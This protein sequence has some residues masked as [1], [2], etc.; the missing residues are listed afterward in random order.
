M[1][2]SDMS[3]TCPLQC[4]GAP[5]VRSL[6]HSLDSPNKTIFSFPDRELIKPERRLVIQGCLGRVMFVWGGLCLSGEGYVCLGRV[7]FV[8][9]GFCMSGEGYVCLG[10][11]LYVWGGLC[12]SGEGFVCLGRVIFVCSPTTA[13][14]CCHSLVC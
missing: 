12:L 2:H 3:T 13:V 4:P 1:T 11:V 10:R 7:M 8:W 6:S 14:L 5:V 9:G